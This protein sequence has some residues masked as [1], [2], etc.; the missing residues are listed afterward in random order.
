MRRLFRRGEKA[1][2]SAEYW[3]RR[4]E[5]G[6]TSGAGS[7]GALAA[8][9]AEHVNGLVAR[10]GIGSVI[11]FGSGDGN[12]AALFDFPGYTGVD[13]VPGV[14]EAARRRFA[15]RPSWRFLTADDYAAAPVT[16]EL[17]MSLDVI[18]HLVEDA[19]FEAYMRTLAAAAGRY[20]LV[21]ASDH[22]AETPSRHVRHR[23]YS[24]WLAAEA[25]ALEPV[26]TWANPHAWTEG[27]DPEATSFAFFRLYARTGG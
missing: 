5:A 11:E 25:A 7:A 2:H 20:L 24:R 14:V 9:K 19:V 27:A 22:D 23:A 26:E 15:D 18:Y 8:Y 17:A 6:G 4:Y 13:V 21:Y 16:A 1:F 12:Q 3:A 10:L